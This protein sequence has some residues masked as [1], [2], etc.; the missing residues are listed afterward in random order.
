M[1]IKV[2]EFSGKATYSGGKLTNLTFDSKEGERNWHNAVKAGQRKLYAGMLSFVGQLCQDSAFI[3]NHIAH[4]FAEGRNSKFG[5]EY[6]KTLHEF[7]DMINIDGRDDSELIYSKAKIDA[8][9]KAAVGSYFI[10]WDER[11]ANAREWLENLSEEKPMKIILKPGAILPTRAHDTDAGLDLYSPGEVFIQPGQSTVIDT[12]VCIQLPPNTVGF[13]KSKSGLMVK[14]N[15][16]TD[17]TI[18]VG[19]TGSIRIKLFNLGQEAFHL[20]KRSKIAQLVIC[21]IDIPDMELVS[22]LEET[23]RGENGF[24]SSGR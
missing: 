4:G 17:G 2:R 11:Y 6:L 1:A 9:V 13:V 7:S 8:K 15:I 22:E 5:I 20:E 12:G 21:R 18:D 24:G 3:A 10:P 19:Y 14:N 16:I 23:E